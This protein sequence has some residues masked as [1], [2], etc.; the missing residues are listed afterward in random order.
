MLELGLAGRRALINGGGAGLGLAAA[1][2]LA[3]QGVALALFG[4]DGPELAGAA[5]ETGALALPGTR[6]AARR[7]RRR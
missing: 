6:R 1:R 2:A 7:S 5:S 4:R 3:G